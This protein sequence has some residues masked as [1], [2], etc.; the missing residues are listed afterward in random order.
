MFCKAA[1]DTNSRDV[2]SCD[3]NS[4][5]LNGRV[6]V[7][8]VAAFGSVVQLNAMKRYNCILDLSDK[9][10]Y[11]GVHYA[12]MS[13]NVETLKMLHSNSCDMHKKAGKLKRSPLVIA[14]ICGS[15]NTVKYLVEEVALDHEDVRNALRLAMRYRQDITCSYL[16]QHVY[17]TTE[18]T[19]DDTVSHFF[20]AC[21]LAP[22]Y[23]KAMMNSNSFTK[24][25]IYTSIRYIWLDKITNSY[26]AN[27][28]RKSLISKV[29]QRF[30]AV[31]DWLFGRITDG[32]NGFLHLNEMN[33]ELF[34]EVY[35]TQYIKKCYSKYAMRAAKLYVLA[36]ATFAIVTTLLYAVYG[37]LWQIEL[38]EGRKPDRSDSLEVV[39][40]VI[41]IF[42][43]VCA[44]YLL[45]RDSL[46]VY[47]KLRHMNFTLKTEKAIVE[48]EL[49]SLHSFMVVPRI[50]MEKER[51]TLRR[52]SSGLGIRLVGKIGFTWYDMTVRLLS[53]V[54]VVGYGV[55]Y[56][57][58]SFP[59]L[60][61]LGY[62]II[63]A[64]SFLMFLNWI[65]LFFSL[66]ILPYTG[67]FVMISI[68]VIK[69]VVHFLI[70]FLIC[71][72]PF[73]L[74]F[75]KTIYSWAS[76][77]PDMDGTTIVEALFRTFRMALADYD[78]DAGGS[79]AGAVGAELW[80][81]VLLVIWIILANIILINL[82]IALMG[83]TFG[84]AY[85]MVSNISKR[86]R[87]NY[88]VDAHLMLTDLQKQEFLMYL[89]ESCK[90]CVYRDKCMSPV[91]IESDD[92]DINVGTTSYFGVSSV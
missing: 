73:S 88:A 87:L 19:E 2:E 63:V 86:T 57:D 75:W 84:G 9:D 25:N 59:N 52:Y 51:E 33:I 40:I 5:D 30:E 92:D 18:R 42:W 70:L 69:A 71:F 50:T 11:T 21:V 82:L 45:Y 37:L 16:V 14:A 24:H 41:H 49:G 29:K 46:R 61:S 72:I 58:I 79:V 74:I 60:T 12:A 3:I 1:G 62:F 64:A 35:L 48:T 53:I 77:L 31:K 66:R 34:S 90:P 39:F 20:R 27:H 76:V 38:E 81:D 91:P 15:I 4:R 80:W 67:A 23:A 17:G 32:T 26:E 56:S 54:F 55:A 83:S 7:H 13:D 65:S 47:L 43:I 89:S 85:E 36:N 8:F 28:K 68:R 10:G 44:A 6:A 78:Y 22:N